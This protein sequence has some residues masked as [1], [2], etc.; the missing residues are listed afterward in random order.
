MQFGPLA[1]MGWLRIYG[2]VALS[3]KNLFDW[4]L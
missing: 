2:F 4:M 1:G 3:N